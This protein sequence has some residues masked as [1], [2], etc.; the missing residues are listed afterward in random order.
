MENGRTLTNRKTVNL[1]FT[2]LNVIL[3]F[4]ISILHFL[5]VD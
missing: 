5:T 1:D 3:H 4:D 2:F